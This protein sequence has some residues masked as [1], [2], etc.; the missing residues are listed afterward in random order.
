MELA[1]MSIFFFPDLFLISK[2]SH[3]FLS[4][5]CQVLSQKF[6]PVDGLSFLGAH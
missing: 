4:L 1:C 2:V 5:S 3:E 6:Q